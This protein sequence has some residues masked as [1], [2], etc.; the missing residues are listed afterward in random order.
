MLK[1]RPIFAVLFLI[2]GLV[3]I[4]GLGALFAIGNMEAGMSDSATEGAVVSP[5]PFLVSF[6]AYFICGIIASFVPQVIARI[7]LAFAA[8]VA[9]L[10]VLW[11]VRHQGWPVER[12]FVIITSVIFVLYSLCWIFMFQ[13]KKLL[14]PNTALEPTPTA[15]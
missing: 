12:F 1:Y 4:G 8:H 5:T 13:Q 3:V 2:G 14:P 6:G 15:P 10:R 11:L 7:F 9:P